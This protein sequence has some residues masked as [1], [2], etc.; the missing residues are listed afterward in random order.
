MTVA[1][2]IAARPA[3]QSATRRYRRIQFSLSVAQ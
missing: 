3:G 2:P 1:A